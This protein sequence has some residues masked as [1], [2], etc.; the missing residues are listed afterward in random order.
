[1]AKASSVDLIMA[2]DKMKPL[3]ALSKREPV[4]AALGISADGEGII[5]LDKKAKPKRVLAMLK[6]GAAKAKLQLNSATLRFG[7]AEVDPD[8]DPG[9][10]RFSINKEPPGPYRIKMVELVRRIP[11][12][13]VEFAVDPSLEEEPEEETERQETAADA[14]VANQEAAVAAEAAAQAAAPVQPATEPLVAASPTPPPNEP[15]VAATPPSPDAAN[16]TEQL[17]ALI[18]RIA[19]AAGDDAA[20]KAIL[21]KI[22]GEANGAIR[23]G[24]LNHGAEAI[25]RLRAALDTP[26]GTQAATSA[27]AAGS[28]AG[29]VAYGKARL[30]W[31]STRK[32]IAGDIDQLVGLLRAD[33]DQ[34]G[35][36]DAI[37]TEFRGRVAPIL[38]QLDES[39]AD[40]L[41]DAVNQTD[42]V[43]RGAL[44]AEARSIVG[45]YQTY[46]AGEPLLALIDENPYAPTAI[47]KTLSTTLTALSA[48]IR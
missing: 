23:S 43:R 26:V 41:D 42:A 9:T 47:Q 40:T 21:A 18:G 37:A 33:Y 45:R 34:E 3:L 14:P 16:L 35:L 19:Q 27:A 10:I 15:A 1:M 31:L 28:S 8:Y 2:P 24:D 32:K 4:Q 48:A 11:Y 29:A 22:A 13:K 12:Q 17:R 25:T 39:L 36:G 20:R 38:E 7:H 6:A 44:V 46:L 30:I 5:L